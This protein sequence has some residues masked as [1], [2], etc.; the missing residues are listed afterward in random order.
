MVR[1]VRL[2][3]EQ[4]VRVMHGDNS[5]G[6]G[7]SDTHSFVGPH[8]QSLNSATKP[9][10]RKLRLSS[11][12]IEAKV[13]CDVR[14]H[15]YLVHPVTAHP[16]VRIHNEGHTD[17]AATLLESC[18]CRLPGPVCVYVYITCESNA[19]AHARAYAGVHVRSATT[20]Q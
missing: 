12:P 16:G 11:P 17:I 19:Y 13:Q 18:Y 2:R 14:A 15:M 8:D 1:V 20:D 4:V 7:G 5:D 3:E 9:P 6:G 10:L